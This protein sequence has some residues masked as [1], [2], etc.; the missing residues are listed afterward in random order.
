VICRPPR[1]FSP[2][3]LCS[4]VFIVVVIAALR[5]GNFVGNDVVRILISNSGYLSDGSV[6]VA[7]NG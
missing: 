5:D 2:H 6:T 1:L 4:L 7:N 3:E